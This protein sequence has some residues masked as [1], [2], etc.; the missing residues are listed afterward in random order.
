MNFIDLVNRRQSVRQY[1][2][3]PVDREK[4]EACLEAARL[5]P[6]TSNSQPWKFIVV[7]DPDLTAIVAEETVAPFRWFNTFADQ[8]PVLVAVTADKVSIKAKTGQF[9]RRF[10]FGLI[11]I[12][13]ATEHF[14]LQATELG[15]GTCILGWFHE[16][17]VIKL[18][19]IPRNKR[20]YLMIALGYPRDERVRGKRRKP[21][22]EVRSYNRYR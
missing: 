6:S 2:D 22:A 5:A 8:V 20:V 9:L 17:A 13:I 1:A 11:D 4:I 15:L 14:C 18:L 10:D 19:D 16:K 21:L 12:G 3:K 7:D